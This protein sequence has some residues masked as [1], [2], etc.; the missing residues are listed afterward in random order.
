MSAVIVDAQ[1]IIGV[2]GCAMDENGYRSRAELQFRRSGRSLIV[3]LIALFPVGLLGS[4]LSHHLHS[5][6]P[7]GLSVTTLMVSLLHV[8]VW[9]YVMYCRWTGKYPFYWLRRK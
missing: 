5:D 3:L 6:L 2:N 4:K 9:R 8:S 1:S 7:F